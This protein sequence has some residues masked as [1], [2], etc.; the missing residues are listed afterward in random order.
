[1]KILLTVVITLLIVGGVVGAGFVMMKRDPIAGMMIPV[2]IEPVERGTLIELVQSPGEVQPRE[3][4]SI[5]A[6]IAARIVDL[7]HEEGANVEKDA[8]LVRLDSSDLEA[9]LRSTEARYAAQ[10]ASSLVA[11]SRVEAQRAQLEGVRATLTD[12]KRDLERQQDLLRTQDVSQ[13]VVDAA[14]RRV[15]ESLA[16]VQSAEYTLKAEETNLQVLKHNLE[17]ADADIARAREDLSYTTITSPL[18]G[19]ITTIN[20]KVGE[21]VVTGTMNNAGTVI[22]EVADLSQMLVVARVDET[23]VAS[24]KVGQPARV[25]MQAYPD[26]V[27]TG[28]VASVALARTTERNAGANASG[29]AKT[30]KVEILLDTG[31]ERIYSGLTADVEIETRRHENILK[32]PSQA[33]LGAATD[34]LPQVVRD[35]DPNVDKSKTLT[36]VVYRY[37]NG[38]AVVTPVKVGASDITHTVIE[39]GVSQG[40]QIITGPY[41]VLEHLFND[42]PV[43]PE[44]AATQPTSMPSQP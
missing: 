4:V 2:R 7:P 26:R 30:F 43:Q 31:G 20:A 17:A 6:K 22:M 15:Q 38:K 34:D 19:V 24:V 27:F 13:S 12:A 35:N 41:K 44:T 9:Q 39:D 42:Q 11:K 36:T 29:D 40:D 10:Q 21:L 5:S 16:S 28:K 25:H 1:V 14:V 33:V 3:K 37:V 18:K 32:V 23:D 8:V